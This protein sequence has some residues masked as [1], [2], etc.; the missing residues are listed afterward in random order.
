MC[1]IAPLADVAANA[2]VPEAE[3]QIALLGQQIMSEVK[4][5]ADEP[6]TSAIDGRMY[7]ALAHIKDHLDCARWRSTSG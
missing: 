3:E 1:R 5:E 6:K 7:Q 2:P 4:R